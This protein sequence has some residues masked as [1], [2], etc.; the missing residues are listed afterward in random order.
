[1]RRLVATIAGTALVTLGVAVVNVPAAHAVGATRYVA[2][3]GSDASNSCTVQ[4]SPCKTLGHA[5]AVAVS[6]DEISI[7]AGTYLESDNPAG[8]SNV[9]P[10]RLHTL[11]IE[12]HHALIDA[13]NEDHGLVV[14][15]T[16][17]QVFDLDVTTS[18][19]QGILVAPPSDATIPAA[20]LDFHLSGS[21]ITRSGG[22][23][24][25]LISTVAA[26]LENNTV[27]NN[28]GGILLTDELGPNHGNGLSH[29]IA[30][31]NGG[32][33][34]IALIG[35]NPRALVTSGEHV[36]MRQSALGGIYSNELADNTTNGNGGAGIIMEGDPSG[37]A[38]Y[39]NRLEDNTANDNGRA[40]IMIQRHT[41]LQDLND[42]TITANHVSHDAV[43]GNNGE[44]GD[45]AAGDFQT[46]GILV[47]SETAPI[48]GTAVT[49]NI[50]TDVFYGVWLSQKTP[51]A[52]VSHNTT[53]V[54][55]GGS[56]IFL[57]RPVVAPIVGMARTPSGK[58]Y[59]IAQSDGA[60]F[61][62]G[63][64]AYYGSLGGVSLARPIVGIA[65]SP[66]G[67][68]YWLVATDG[69]VFAFGDAH[70]YGSTG[71]IRLNQPV[72]G[73]TPTPTGHGYWFVASDGG[74]FAYG[75]AHFYGSTGALHLVKPVVGMATGPN[76]QGYWL[77]ASDGGVFSFGSAKFHGSMGAVV[78]NEPVVGMT[79]GPDGAGYWLVASD[80]GIFTFGSA[81]FH[82][83]TGALQLLQPIV[84]MQAS[85][86]NRGY[87]LVARDG[88]IFSFGNAQYHGS[89]PAIY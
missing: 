5:L 14:N 56:P 57:D 26:S 27:T 53:T 24:V 64:A 89:V 83:S 58:G 39:L 32:G 2:T 22:A 33:D 7:A 49:R 72:V 79:Q 29:N 67:L 10:A 41:A 46:T 19:Q 28:A 59:W 15:A 42:N 73:M 82:G 87:W 12:A 47:L 68:G 52:N 62:F 43:S 71:N 3:T 88:G 21:T 61:A 74:V 4:V 23:A 1:M 25:Q 30:N 63:D 65:P 45:F 50:I 9:V 44:P 40:G 81:T 60:V 11:V 16:G 36:G 8:T 55:E 78:L 37:S 66:T 34:G 17:V 76:G 80:G 75:D 31:G 38:V 69:G 18:S 35:N 13:T 85:P 70:F 84:A 20:I 48:T 77:D 51:S 86:T 6:G 54:T